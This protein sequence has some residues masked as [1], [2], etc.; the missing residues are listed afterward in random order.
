MAERTSSF[1]SFLPCCCCCLVES[2][3]ITLVCTH[4]SLLSSEQFSFQAGGSI[5]ELLSSTHTERIETTICTAHTGPHRYL[6]SFSR[7]ITTITSSR[8]NFNSSQ[9]STRRSSNKKRLLSD[10]QAKEDSVNIF[11]DMSAINAAAATNKSDLNCTKNSGSS[12]HTLTTLAVESVVNPLLA[13]VVEN[14]IVA[15]EEILMEKSLSDQACAEG[16]RPSSTGTLYHVEEVE[17]SNNKD[18]DALKLRQVTND[19]M[20]SASE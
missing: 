15:T 11:C 12:P 9:N 6:R 7:F 14:L 1:L 3:R 13:N 4:A 20:V 8:S 19:I 5:L 10:E 2:N 16:R 18:S 17:V